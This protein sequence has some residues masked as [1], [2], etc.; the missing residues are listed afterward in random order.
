MLRSE[1]LFTQQ[2]HYIRLSDLEKW[3]GEE[4]IQEISGFTHDLS[5]IDHI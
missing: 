2:T 1:W 3:S 4:K 5:Y